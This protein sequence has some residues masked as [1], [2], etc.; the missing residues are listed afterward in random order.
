MWKDRISFRMAKAAFQCGSN[1]LKTVSKGLQPQ[2]GNTKGNVNFLTDSDLKNLSD[3]VNSLD[4]EPSFACVHRRQKEYIID[5]ELTSM[6]AVYARY[7]LWCNNQKTVLRAM[8]QSTFYRYIESY[9]CTLAVNKLKEDECD[10]C[11]ELKE[12]KNL[13]F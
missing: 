10:T 11:I 13:L 9:H 1:R 4:T 2:K 3:F 7:Q 12:G 5:P 6:R 8:G